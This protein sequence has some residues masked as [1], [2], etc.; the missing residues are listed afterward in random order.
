MK[1]I[2]WYKNRSRGEDKI[3]EII[4]RYNLMGIEIIKKLNSKNN[5]LIIFENGDI[6]RLIAVADNVKAQRCN[7]SLIEQNIEKNFI[8]AI[9]KPYTTAWPFTAYNYY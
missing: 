7:I 4:N 2:V 1:G 6:W 8:N 9:I 3:N 5:S